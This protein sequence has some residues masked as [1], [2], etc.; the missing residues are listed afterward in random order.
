M[1]RTAARSLVVWCPDWPVLAAGADLDAPVAI[2]LGEGARRSVVACSPAARA[3]GVRRGQR[4]RDAQRLCPALELYRRDEA[5]EARA[6]EPVVLAAEQVAAGVEVVRPGLLALD[7]RGPARYHGGEQVLGELVRNEVALLSTASGSPVGVGVG[8]ADGIFAAGLAARTPAAEGPVIVPVGGSP[9]F[10]ADFPVGVL[11]CPADFVDLLDRLGVRTLG[12]FAALPTAAVADRFGGAGMVFHRLAQG[13]DPR[14]PAARRPPR[15]L[16]VE[17][18]LDPPAEW[19]EPVVFVAKMLADE[20]HTNLA[21]AGLAGVR[22][23]VEITTVSGRS[24]VRRWRHADAAGGRLTSAAVAERVRWQLDGWRTREPYPDADPVALLRLVPDQLVVDAGSQ[25]ALWG[26][27]EIPDR[28]GRVAER[29]QALLGHGGVVRLRLVGGRSPASRIEQVPWGEAFGAD[30]GLDAPW[31]GAVPAPAPSGVFGDGGLRVVEVLGAGLGR[32]PGPGP[33][34]GAASGAGAGPESATG[35][36]SKP[37]QGL[38]PRPRPGL[39]PEPGT[40]LGPGTRAG[41]ESGTGAGTGLRSKPGQRLGP[42]PRPRPGPGPGPSPEPGPGDIRGDRGLR[43]TQA[44]QP[45]RSEVH[46]DR[47]L[48]LA[49][50]RGP[51]RGPDQDRRSVRR[52]AAD[53]SWPRSPADVPGEQPSEKPGKRSSEQLGEKPSEQPGEWFRERPGEKP[54]ERSSEQQGKKPSERLGERLGERPSERLGDGLVLVQGAANQAAEAPIGPSAMIPIGVS[55]RSQ[56][57]GV[58]TILV[59]DGERLPVLGWAG[60]WVYERSW[61]ATGRR[62]R[63]RLQCRVADGRVLLLVLEHGTW[64]LEAVYQ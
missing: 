54:R 61:E 26:A 38:G 32:R 39:G 23:D 47:H 14:P 17:H 42:E 44:P 60:P 50:A 9:G 59:V 8:I 12:A 35:L 49:E 48:W 22:L 25:Q 55:G 16:A 1:D 7:A 21:D 53:R 20:L 10:L 46:N 29:V 51:V 15:E 36:K 40:G 37:G 18:E 4:L 45:G 28:V 56:L 52:A 3:A 11:D 24:C 57:T 31:P 5:A 64:R 6:F 2:L 19:D 33:G 27:E 43:P 63:A 13:L 41:A 62:R 30:A 58:P 34:T